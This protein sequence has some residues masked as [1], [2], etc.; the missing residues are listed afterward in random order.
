M[1]NMI[2]LIKADCR[3]LIFTRT[4]LLCVL[5]VGILDILDILPH[6]LWCVYR[7]EGGMLQVDYTVIDAVCTSGY[8]MFNMA[9][10]SVCVLSA[11]SGYCID[12]ESNVTNGILMRS[13]HKKYAAASMISCAVTAFLCMLLGEIIL[14]VFYR[15]FG[16]VSEAGYGSMSTYPLLRSG[17]YWLYI[18]AVLV[19]RG[20]RG[21]FFAMASFMLSAFVKNK[22]VVASIPILM[23]YFLQH[24]GYGNFDTSFDI[25]NVHTVYY[26]FR[27]KTEGW[28]LLYAFSYTVTAGILFGIIFYKKIRRRES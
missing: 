28:S 12:M 13:S 26:F 10:L 16:P 25:L 18:A 2:R 17:H 24:F 23:F 5:G 1:N 3:K 22:F 20:L 7:D 27:L 9:A 6:F 14:V 19:Q 4:F 21:A 8:T 11:S 15:Q